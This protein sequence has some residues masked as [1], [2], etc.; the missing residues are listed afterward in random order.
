MAENGF[1]GTMPPLQAGALPGS[2]S[3]VALNLENALMPFK[4]MY[5]RKEQARE[6]DRENLPHSPHERS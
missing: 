2:L 1:N 6:E 4:Q 5:A 3:L